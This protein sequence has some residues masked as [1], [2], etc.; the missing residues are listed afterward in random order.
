M[1]GLDAPAD[2]QGGFN[3]TYKVGPKL[4]G[5]LQVQ[6]AV[7]NQLLNKTITNVLATIRGRTEPDRYVIVGH[8]RDSHT[9]GALDSATGTALFLQIAG[10]FAALVRGGWRPRRSLLF[11]SWGAEEFNLLGSTEWVEEMSK[12]LHTRAIAYVNINRPVC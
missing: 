6:V 4:K 12:I 2:W 7:H 3:F 5:N 11:C 1:D 8:K 9:S 10:S